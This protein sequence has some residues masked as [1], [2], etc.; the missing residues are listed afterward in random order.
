MA[1]LEKFFLKIRLSSS[2]RVRNF[3]ALNEPASE[4]DL[5]ES[6][7]FDRSLLKSKAQRFSE[8]FPPIPH[9]ARAL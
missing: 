8:K 9:P 2:I 7:I 1:K 5:A 4:M 3:A 6:G